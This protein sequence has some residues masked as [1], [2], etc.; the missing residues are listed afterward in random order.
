MND[1]GFMNGADIRSF[2]GNLNFNQFE[3][4]GPFRSFNLGF[5]PSASWDF[6]GNRLHTQTNAWGNMTFRNNWH[7]GAWGSRAFGGLSTGA[8]R[9]GPAIVQPGRWMFNGW[10]NSD[11]RKPVWV[12]AFGFFA[13]DDERSGWMREGSI[14][15]NA[16]PSGALDL[17]FGPRITERGS[18]WQYVSQVEDAAGETHYVFAGIRQQMLSLTTRLTYTFAPTLSLQVYAQP[19]LTAGSY[20]SFREVD[21][22]RAAAFR[23][24]FHVFTP[25]ELTYVPAEEEGGWGEYEVDRDGDGAADYAFGEPDFNFKELRSNVV[26]RWEYRPGSAAFLVWSQGRSHTGPDGAFR[27]GQDMDTL[28]GAAGSNVLALKIS[29]WLDI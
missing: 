25:D 1:A 13:R 5:N 11:P 28:L 26:L 7:L 16:R 14:T 10:G 23:D 24:R 12:E 3:P 17:Q 2:Y 19:F 20:G 15:M 9:G 4:V 29:Y 8:L 22:P 21:D 27:F 18:D 6:G